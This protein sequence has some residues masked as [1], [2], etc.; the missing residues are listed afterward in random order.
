MRR[1]HFCEEDLS[2]LT[3]L[4]ELTMMQ[5]Y[6]FNKPHDRGTFE[7]FYRKAPYEGEFVVFAGA[8]RVLEQ[9][10]SLRFYPRQIDYL[11]SLGIFQEPFL[12]YLSSFCFQGEVRAIAEGTPVFPLEPLLEV[13]GSL[14][15]GQ[16]IETLLLN[17]INY[18]SLIA[19]KAARISHAAQGKPVLEFG[20]RRAHGPAGGLYASR[21]AIIGGCHSTSNTLAGFR[22]GAK[23]SGTMAHSWVM[24]FASEEESFQVYGDLYPRNSVFL[25]DT[26]DTL[27]TG[28]PCAIRAAKEMKQKGGSPVGIRLDSGDFYALSIAARKMLDEAG[29]PEMKIFASGDLDEYSID[30]L[31]KKGAPIDAYGV[32]T[33]LTTG[34]EQ[35][36]L[37][38]VY[39]LSAIYRYEP[40]NQEER[41]RSQSQ[42][43]R[44]GP[45]KE[46]FSTP[47]EGPDYHYEGVIKIS[48]DRVK[49][50]LPGKKNILRFYQGGKMVADL[51]VF[52]QEAQSALKKAKAKEK[53]AA[54]GGRGFGEPFEI[55]EYDEGE[56]LLNLLIEKGSSK[57][58]PPSLDEI[59]RFAQELYK[60]T[61]L[62]AEQGYPVCISENIYSERKKLLDLKKKG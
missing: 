51:I 15:E 21:A 18:E 27:A 22:Y 20:L 6:F 14:I 7:L 42:S 40:A 62:Q 29:L 56:V 34:G 3:D 44:G 50:T 11:S 31:E 33:R 37:G 57:E 5:G 53:F 25:V 10:S 2:L 60:K 13:S 32:G 9:L 23:I 47:E 61:P 26:Y 39:K 46:E 52:E 55:Y 58:P 12:E 48:D 54:W 49:R 24:S 43:L 8:G 28:L 16:W 19:T 41:T 35:S 30:E 4:Y 36:A 1:V 59:S 38:G 45:E 17:S